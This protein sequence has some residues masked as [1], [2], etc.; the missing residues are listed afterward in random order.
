MKFP[1]SWLLLNRWLWIIILSLS[2]ITIGPFVVIIL[3]LSVPSPA[4]RGI[5][6]ILLI[7]G[8]GVAAGFKDWARSKK[9]EKKIKPYVFETKD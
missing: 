5:G 6:T 8:W 9:N 4:F 1:L 3:M 2:A 7:C